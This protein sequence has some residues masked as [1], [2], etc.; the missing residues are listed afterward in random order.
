M[1]AIL[2]N[3]PSDLK[4]GDEIITNA[5]SEMRYYRVMEVP[6]ESTKSPYT[7]GD[8]RKRYIAVRCRAALVEKS[9]SGVNWNNKPWTRNWKEYEF[10]TPNQDDPTVKV[11]LNYKNMVI[12]KREEQWT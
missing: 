1:K 3:N 7:W 8:K 10:R 2:T 6:R 12:V 5:G 4:I 11:D 9:S